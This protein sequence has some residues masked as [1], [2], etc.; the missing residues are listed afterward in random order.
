[1][2]AD[3]TITPPENVVLG[4]AIAPT[5]VP[6]SDPAASLSGTLRS[7]ATPPMSAA[8][9]LVLLMSRAA[10]AKRPRV[11]SVSVDEATFV[12]SRRSNQE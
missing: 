5:K 8:M 7:D 12:T 4:P 10:S 2:S 11:P 3:S 9:A 1:M 6:P